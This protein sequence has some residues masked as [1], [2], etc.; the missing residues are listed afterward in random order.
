MRAE[1]F[2]EK[3]GMRDTR[4]CPSNMVKLV[5]TLVENLRKRI[6][7]FPARYKSLL[8][9]LTPSLPVA[10]DIVKNTFIVTFAL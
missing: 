7:I 6:T 8:I 2:I 1:N 3:L 4:N 9:I 10:I 5:F